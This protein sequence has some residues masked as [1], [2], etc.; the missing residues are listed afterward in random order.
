METGNYSG[1][2]VHYTSAAGD[3]CTITYTESTPHQLYLGVRRTDGAP[4]IQISIDGGPT[5]SVL[6][7]LPGEDALI[8]HPLSS[9]AAGS[10]AVT[11][12]HAGQDQTLYF[13][14]LEIVYPSNNLPDF[15]AN[16]QLSLATDWDTYHSQSLP[17]ERTAWLIHKLG[18]T[19]RVNHYV[20][21]LWFYEIVRPGTKYATL[22][23]ELQLLP[24]HGSPYVQFALAA[25]V[26]SLSSS[27]TSTLVSHL[28]LPDDDSAGVALAIAALINVGTNLV[29]ASTN[30]DK[31]TV[32]A[33]AMGTVGNGIAFQLA[34]SSPDFAV[35]ASSNVL[36]GGVDGA[37]YDLTHDRGLNDT[38]MTEA[39]FWRTDLNIVPRINRAARDWHAAYFAA[40]K[41]YGMDAVAA[42]STE[43]M[44]G[45]PSATAGIAQRYPDG[46][47]AV[48]NT[49]AIQTNFSPTSLVFWTQVYLDMALL[50]STAGLIPYLQ[51]GEVQWWYFPNSVGMPFYDAYTQQQFTAKYG[52]PMQ[53]IPNS[54][55]DP[56]AYPN[57]VAFLPTLIGTY[58][59]GIRSALQT[60]YPGCR[61]EVLYPTDTNNTALNRLI[62][63]PATDWTPAN[64]TCLKTE[65][66]GF[67]G[68]HDLVNCTMSMN[69]SAVKGFTNTQRAHLVGVGD[70]WSAWLKEVDIAQSQGLESVVLFALDQYCLV[71]YSPPPFVNSTN[72]S[73]QG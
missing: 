36:S 2:K 20:G 12:T 62:N 1:S 6:L 10:H 67:T 31:L 57:E 47:P 13:D 22:T 25:D 60:A 58:T 28:V 17:A 27:S 53:T 49:P 32:T 35:I 65:S 38:L 21:A 33:R 8:R 63:Y 66:F 50:Q 56:S 54:T 72:S 34:S 70:L 61:Y 64:L 55:V 48:L 7:T 11:V 15:P 40:I 45:D 37:P 41:G 73:R 3:S 29:W 71:G 43:L 4:K 9:I 42:F 30:G 69:T 44:N 59:G 46:T 23:V 19:G 39:S 14:F 18:F 51:S 26:A 68:G 5:Q 52:V 24:T 16:T